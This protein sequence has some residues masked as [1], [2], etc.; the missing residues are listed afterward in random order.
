MAP[1]CKH[2]RVSESCLRLIPTSPTWVPD[3]G[4][5]ARGEAALA[6]L[7]PD[8][9]EVAARTYDEIT[10]I[11][12]GGN[13][14]GINC[15]SCGAEVSVPWWQEA[16]EHAYESRFVRPEV[17]MTCCGTPTSLNELRYK[18]PMGL[19]RWELVASS[20]RRMALKAEEVEELEEAVGY[21]LRQIWTHI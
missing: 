13:F 15:P 4:S 1:G 8:A 20:P 12:C 17:T 7:A 5:A 19:A 6:R 16:I 3:E 9:R 10:F 2:A 21:P 18:W 14:E 11:D